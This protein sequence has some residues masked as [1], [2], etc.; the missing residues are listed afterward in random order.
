MTLI[1]GFTLN[2]YPVVM[3]D[4]LTTMSGPADTK[5]NIPSVG[6]GFHK[7]TNNERVIISNRVQKINILSD[8]TIFCWSGRKIIARSIAKEILEFNKSKFVKSNDIK[9]IINSYPK[10]VVDDFSC[11]CL[12]LQEE[13]I[14]L[15]SCNTYQHYDPFID[16]VSVSGSGAGRFIETLHEIVQARDIEN[17]EEPRVYAMGMALNVVASLLGEEVLLGKNLPLG[18]GGMF[19]VAGFFDGHPVKLDNILFTFWVLKEDTKEGHMGDLQPIY[20]RTQYQN[21][22]LVNRVIRGN[23]KNGQLGADKEELYI[24][25]PLLYD[26]S[27]LKSIKMPD[28]DYEWLVSYV[29]VLLETGEVGAETS[30][31]YCPP[32]QQPLRI[33]E[34]AG[35]FDFSIDNDFIR[36]IFRHG[37]NVRQRAAVK[38]ARQ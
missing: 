15:F 14:H 26:L 12:V 32:G 29:L 10:K 17:N 28:F 18:F 30:V 38:K 9:K 2:Q 4:I 6:D 33:H 34:T 22:L 5:T 20:I 16:N 8:N 13:H 11:I 27:K 23:Y 36:D 35:T 1:A 37:A 31:L 19:E 25:P 3:G 24:T 21:D 7:I